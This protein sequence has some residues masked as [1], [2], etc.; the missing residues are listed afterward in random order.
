MNRCLAID[1]DSFWF[2]LQANYPYLQK[3]KNIPV[4][5]REGA[6]LRRQQSL[7]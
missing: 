6:L 3:E 2:K 5:E 4:M 1:S 7:S